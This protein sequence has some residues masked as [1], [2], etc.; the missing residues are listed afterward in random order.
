M[1]TN[2]VEVKVPGTNIDIFSIIHSFTKQKD[3]RLYDSS[4]R[5][6]D[7]YTRFWL[8]YTAQKKEI[9]YCTWTISFIAIILA[10]Y[11]HHVAGA[12]LLFAVEYQY[13]LFSLH[14]N[15]KSLPMEKYINRYQK[16]II[17]ADTPLFIRYRPMVW[18]LCKKSQNV[19]NIS[20]MPIKSIKHKDFSIHSQSTTSSSRQRKRKLLIKQI[21]K[22]KEGSVNF[23]FT[24][25]LKDFVNV[26]YK[27]DFEEFEFEYF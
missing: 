17:A 12:L 15:I 25:K 6:C 5:I 1:K 21:E 27:D 3:L 22:E 26:V 16:E 23:P 24:L 20:V 7:P 4:A 9:H 8:N 11:D 18:Y 2:S 10:L 13:G 14:N 19:D